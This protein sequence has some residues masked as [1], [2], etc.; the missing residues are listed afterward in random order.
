MPENDGASAGGRSFVLQRKISAPDD[1]PERCAA[2]FQV[3]K[4]AGLSALTVNLPP[5]EPPAPQNPGAK[6][7]GRF[8]TRGLFN[9]GLQCGRSGT[10]LILY[11]FEHYV[12]NITICSWHYRLCP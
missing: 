8:L 12:S 3:Q 4:G 2:V 11:L 6:Y 7:M 10:L 9:P 1:H 5:I